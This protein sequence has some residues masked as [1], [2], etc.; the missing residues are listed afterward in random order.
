MPS[1]RC[2][3]S[4]P[5]C[6]VKHAGE[7]GWRERGAGVGAG[8]GVQYSTARV[9]FLW[10]GWMGCAMMKRTSRERD[11]QPQR[12]VQISPNPSIAHS[13]PCLS[14]STAVPLCPSPSAKIFPACP[15][16]TPSWAKIKEAW[17]RQ[18]QGGGEMGFMRGW[19]AGHAGP[20]EDGVWRGFIRQPALL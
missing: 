9:G 11:S 3:R 15:R 13:T 1:W 19:V 8:A 5:C 20:R 4:R 16:R 14:C 7:A 12:D 17:R 10:R 6:S 2:N 18:H